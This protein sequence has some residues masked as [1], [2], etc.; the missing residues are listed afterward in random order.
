MSQSA[1][2]E[3]PQISSNGLRNLDQ[4]LQS[5]ADQGKVPGLATLIAHHGQILHHGCYGKLNLATGDPIEPNS[6]FRIYS[7][8]KPITAG[9]ALIL[10][11]KGYFDLQDPISNWIPEFKN[12][13]VL[14]K[15]DNTRVAYTELER[16]ITFWHVLTH[17][18]GFGYGFEPEDPLAGLYQEAGFFDALV[19]LQVTLPEL[20]HR[21]A[22]LP[23][24]NQPGEVFRYSVSYDVLPY[25]IELIS[26]EP[27]EAYLRQHV[28]QPLKMNDTGFFVPADRRHRLGPLYNRPGPNG[29]VPLEE[30]AESPF[31]QPDS[32]CS[33]GGGLISTIP[34]YFRFF[35]MLL[36]G[37]ELDGIRLLKTETV[38]Q[39]IRPQVKIRHGQGMGYGLGVGVQIEDQRPD[40]FPEGAFGWSGGGGTEAWADPQTHSVI[41]LMYQVL[42]YSE[43]A[44]GFRSMAFRAVLA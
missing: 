34:D 13:K 28:F 25:L 11:E 38:K 27:F 14:K 6:L 41:I 12:L 36:N 4:A 8:T 32:V 40:G 20:V 1:S 16:E 9:A 10:H 21:L 3:N 26:G 18:A 17:T 7:L 44:K 23:L 24:A 39:M 30:P 2:R 29:I 22:Q 42:A 35:S 31:V 15:E 37:G 19:R 33:G 43:P 5:F